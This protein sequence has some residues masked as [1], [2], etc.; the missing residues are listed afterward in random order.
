[1]GESD[2]LGGVNL[3]PTYSC[4]ILSLMCFVFIVSLIAYFLLL[5][6]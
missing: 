1:M 4:H 6:L 2:N 5:K 3:K